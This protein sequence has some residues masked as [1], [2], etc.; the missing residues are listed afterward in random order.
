M[1]KKK[2]IPT[3]VFRIILGRARMLVSKMV[4]NARKS[5]FCIFRLVMRGQ[6]S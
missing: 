1:G 2:T 3:N 4:K 6:V 5:F